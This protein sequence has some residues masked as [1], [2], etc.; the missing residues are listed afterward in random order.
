MTQD[1]YGP[2]RRGLYRSR[3]G[4]ILGV[5]HGLAEYMDFSVFWTRA[6]VLASTFFTGF[7]PGVGLYF[8]AA[9]L[10]KPEPIVPLDTPEDAEFYTCYAGSRAMALQR[11][12][13]MFDHLDR[14]IQRMEHVV[15]AREYDW[16]RRL[17]G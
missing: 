8:L 1:L 15:T 16:D 3:N 9:L 4:A 12:Q 14:R 11:L 2:R 17:Q 5:C 7:W 10:M 6:V 13:R